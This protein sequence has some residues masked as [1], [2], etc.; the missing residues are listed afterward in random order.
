MRCHPE[1]GASRLRDRRHSAI[2]KAVDGDYAAV[3]AGGIPVRGIATGCVRTVPH[4]GFA[5]V[6]DDKGVKGITFLEQW[7]EVAGIKSGGRL[8]RRSRPPVP[9]GEG[10][11]AKAS[12]A[13]RLRMISVGPSK[14]ISCFRFK[15]LRSLVTVSRE[16]PIRWAISS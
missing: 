16:A 4:T 8:R 12:S 9:R 6:Q 11:T 14:R 3:C 5:G 15:S 7:E 2:S 10:Q 13:D 1:D